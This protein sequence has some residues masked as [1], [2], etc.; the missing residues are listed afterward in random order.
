MIEE[1]ILPII[2]EVG[3]P[4]FVAVLLLCDKIKTNGSLSKVVTNNNIILKRI[5]NKL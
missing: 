4:I 1:A 5:E 3:F 2:K